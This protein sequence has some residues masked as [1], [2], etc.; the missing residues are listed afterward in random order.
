MKNEMEEIRIKLMARK[1]ELGITFREVA[2]RM[3]KEVGNI[4]RV[5]SGDKTL[6]RK[7]AVQ[8][9]EALGIEIVLPEKVTKKK[10]SKEW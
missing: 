4:Y 7:K 9:S 10:E 5:M 8:I 3:G 6:S 2:A 1:E